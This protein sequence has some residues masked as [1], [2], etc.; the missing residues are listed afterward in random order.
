MRSLSE[1]I[2]R[3]QLYPLQRLFIQSSTQVTFSRIKEKN[4][5][6]F[7]STGGRAVKQKLAVNL[8]WL[9]VVIDFWNQYISCGLSEIVS[10]H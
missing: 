7:L 10:S 3:K 5:K 4:S 8:V 1:R 9:D 2:S 6:T